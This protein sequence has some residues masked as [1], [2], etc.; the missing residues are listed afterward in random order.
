MWNYNALESLEIIWQVG[1][2]ILQTCEDQEFDFLRFQL[3]FLKFL[4]T[5]KTKPC[6]RINTQTKNNGMAF[7]MSRRQKQFHW[8]TGSD[9]FF[10]LDFIASYVHVCMFV[11]VRTCTHRW[12]VCVCSGAHRDRKRTLD[13][14]N[15]NHLRRGTGNH[16]CF[17]WNSSVRF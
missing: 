4:Y 6:Q 12:C 11:C 2:L 1:K 8:Q 9:I 3:D 15:W 10:F 17:L 5:M 7:W 16:I 13:P 14:Q